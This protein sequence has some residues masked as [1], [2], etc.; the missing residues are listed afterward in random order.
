MVLNFGIV[1]FGTT[2]ILPQFLQTVLDLGPYE[3]G[4]VMPPRGIALFCK[5][6]IVGHLYNLVDYRILMCSGVAPAFISVFATSRLTMQTDYW[7]MVSR[8]VIL[9][10]GMSFVFVTL[11]TVAFSTTSVT[12]INSATS[13]YSLERRP[14]GNLGNASW[15]YCS[16]AARRFTV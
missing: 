6:P 1:M 3:T 15:R 5:M 2:F 11:T 4:L 9:G 10:F 14:G 8:L 16:N 12:D 7:G 13:L